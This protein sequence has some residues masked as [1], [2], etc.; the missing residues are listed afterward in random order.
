MI[1]LELNPTDEQLSQFGWIALIGF[2]LVGYVI[3]NSFGLGP[4]LLYVL[5]GIGIATLLLSLVKPRLILPVFLGMSLIAVPIGF[6]ISWVLMAL[7][8]YGLFTPVGLLFRLT[9]RDKLHKHPDPD[10]KTYWHDHGPQRSPASYFQ[11][12]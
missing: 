3:T 5:G 10:A 4:T 8:Y 2:P 6:V 9:G 12:H 7:V 11:M 1:K